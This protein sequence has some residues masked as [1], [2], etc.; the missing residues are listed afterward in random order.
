MLAWFWAS[1]IC[2][3]YENS[4]RLLWMTPITE[5]EIPTSSDSHQVDYRGDCSKW[6]LMSWMHAGVLAV[7]MLHCG[8]CCLLQCQCFWTSVSGFW[9]WCNVGFSSLGI[10]DET[11]SGLE[12]L[13]LL[14]SKVQGFWSAPELKT[15]SVSIL[16]SRLNLY[17]CSNLK[18][19]KKY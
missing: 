4:F 18:I 9:W 10:C 19:N 13:I 6:I 1:R 16:V 7:K 11:A 12:Q 14:Q 5:L 17:C 3:L 8:S 15:Y 2:S